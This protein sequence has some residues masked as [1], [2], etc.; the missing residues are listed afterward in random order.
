MK[1]YC[2]AILL[3]LTGCSRDTVLVQS[4]RP[5]PELKKDTAASAIYVRQLLMCGRIAE[6]SAIARDGAERGDA[7]LADLYMSIL[8]QNRRVK[9]GLIYAVKGAENGDLHASKWLIVIS[10]D[11]DLGYFD[12]LIT[13]NYLTFFKSPNPYKYFAQL[14][15]LNYSLSRELVGDFRSAPYALAFVVMSK[16]S[17]MEDF[18][19]E[20]VLSLSEKV[21]T[22]A[23]RFYSEPDLNA[24]VQGLVK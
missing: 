5:C 18:Q 22:N 11:N 12:Q 21:R 20:E 8:E 13:K 9:D 6:G 15:Y 24:K 2:I 16:G 3:I 1:I 7:A 17:Y 23:L 10:T 4:A 19:S 14:D